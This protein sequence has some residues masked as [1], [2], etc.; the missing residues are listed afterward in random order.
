LFRVG[1]LTGANPIDAALALIDNDVIVSST[2]G[3]PGMTEP[4]P[5][6]P[7]VGL[8]IAG[9]ST[10]HTVL[11]PMDEILTALK[12]DFNNPNSYMPSGS[13]AVGDPVQKVG[14]TTGYSS[15]NI[16][17]VGVTLA[18]NYGL[19]G[20]VTFKNLIVIEGI[21][22][23]SG[24]A[25]AVVCYGGNGING[26]PVGLPLG[27]CPFMSASSQ[28]LAIPDLTSSSDLQRIDQFRDQYLAHTAVGQLILGLCYL[29]TDYFTQRINSVTA[30][31]PDPYLQSYGQSVYNQYWP[32]FVADLDNPDSAPPMTSDE[33]GYMVLTFGQMGADGY[34]T[35]PEHDAIYNLLAYVIQPTIGM[36]YQQVVAYFNQQSVYDQALGYL[37]TVPTLT[38][39]ANDAPL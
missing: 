4:L 1:S 23:D 36:T 24:D 7:A 2:P 31:G 37:S 16:S 11:Q 22:A 18:I 19:L 6:Q 29:N 30:A 12:A 8:V 5:G 34:F 21:F 35:Q 39:A 3:V 33:Y 9:S 14:R 10:S 15:L 26:A 25:G 28:M 13:V 17:Q 20:P 38:F 32:Q 27:L